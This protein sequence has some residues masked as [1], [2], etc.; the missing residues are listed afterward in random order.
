MGYFATGFSRAKD[1]VVAVNELHRSLQA[2]ESGLIV[3][4]CSS[5]YDLDGLAVA[6]EQR[7][8][9]IPLVGCTTAGCI[10]DEGY[11][12]QG[13]VACSFSREVFSFSLHF[14]CAL[15][16]LSFE[17]ADRAIGNLRKEVEQKADVKNED[18]RLFSFLL[19]DGMCC[20]E[21]SVTQTLY[22]AL[23]GIPLLGGSAGD[24]LKFEKTF[25][26]FERQF[27]TN[28]AVIILGYTSLQFTPFMVQHFL[29]SEQ[30]MVVTDSVPE[31]RVVKELN[32]LPAAKEYARQVGLDSSHLTPMIFA[33]HPVLVK[34]GDETYV[35]SIQK[36]NSD[37]SMTFF[38]AIDDGI[39]LSVA[40]ADDL[41]TNLNN[42]MERVVKQI[43]EPELILGCDCILR[44][45]ELEQ[46]DRVA[47]VSDLL[48]RY[49][50]LGF[51]SYGEQFNSMHVN[52]TLTG[53]AFS[54]E[55]R[56]N[57]D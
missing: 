1:P 32:G 51:N 23:N 55:A 29:S 44:Y 13:I 28:A 14:F 47:Q 8:P 21:E 50:F 49:N 7:F 45:L 9:N 41:V 33:A 30:K 11:Q 36:V 12:Q 20:K 57:D 40:K 4:F 5:D 17:Q 53:I 56:L 22:M 24:G 46:T 42:A 10:G 15:D 37:G 3:F 2:L 6:L 18:K 39:V 26:Y 54:S 19:I 34:I 48:R 52:Q 25:V 35:R 43:G 31:K 38:C 16:S 27:H